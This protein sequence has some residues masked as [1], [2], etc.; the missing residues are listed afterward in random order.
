MVQSLHLSRWNMH[1]E[2]GHRGNL[3]HCSS[4]FDYLPQSG[5]ERYFSQ[6]LRPD[7]GYLLPG[8]ELPSVISGIRGLGGCYRGEQK[9][10]KF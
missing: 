1:L 3:T 7:N 5:F 2:D 8:R 10:G 6:L 4:I 9:L